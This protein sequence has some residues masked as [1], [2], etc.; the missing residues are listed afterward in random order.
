MINWKTGKKKKEETTDR[1]QEKAQNRKQEFV[2]DVSRQTALCLADPSQN[3]SKQNKSFSKQ[4]VECDM[5]IRTEK[6]ELLLR[7]VAKAFK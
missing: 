1:R 3:Q 7:S 4:L 5:K 2:G 6:K